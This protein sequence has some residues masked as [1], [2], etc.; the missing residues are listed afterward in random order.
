MSRVCLRVFAYVCLLVLAMAC[1]G[2]LVGSPR[3]VVALLV[4]W[5]LAFD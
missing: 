1:R 5:V 2:Y 3:V 4:V